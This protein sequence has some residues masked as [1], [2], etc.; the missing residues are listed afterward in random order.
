MQKVSCCSAIDGVKKGS[1]S[2][3]GTGDCPRPAGIVAANLMLLL[4]Y[5]LSSF[6][7]PTVFSYYSTLLRSPAAV[8]WSWTLLAFLV[9]CVAASLFEG[10]RGIR[11]RRRPGAVITVTFSVLWLLLCLLF[12]FLKLEGG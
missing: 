2:E 7:G 5:F 1:E 4:A 10:I 12:L 6:V 8:M 3:R 11:Q 9:L